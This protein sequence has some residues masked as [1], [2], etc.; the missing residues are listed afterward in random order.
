MFRLS[1][2]RQQ[3]GHPPSFR[4]VRLL[5]TVSLSLLPALIMRGESQ[6]PHLQPQGTAVQ[7][8][9]DGQPFLIRG[10]EIGN[11]SA[12]NP[13]TFEQHWPKLKS[14]NLNTVL[15]PVYWHL[16]EPAEG[17]FDFST[18]DD[19]VRQARANRMRLVLLW[20]G[21][22]KNSMSCYAPDWIK[23]DPQRFPRATDRDGRP[24]E[25]LSPFVLENQTR[26]ATAFAKARR[27]CARASTPSSS[28]RSCSRSRSS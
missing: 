23:L 4:G 15:I 8:I 2:L 20:F 11:S 18:V 22:W 19:V 7:L 10:G 25:I 24:Q 14:L 9:V 26:D 21:S 27:S 5:I 13:D 3:Q 28:S 12:T 6:A 17:R 1:D 16:I